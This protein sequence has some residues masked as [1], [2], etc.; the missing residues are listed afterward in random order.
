MT[1]TGARVGRGRAPRGTGTRGRPR[2]PETEQRAL[3]ATLDVFGRKGL[4]GLTIDEVAAVSKVGKSSI[5]L[6]WSNKE[7][8]LAA[9]LRQVQVEAGTG[10]EDG[11]SEAE[12]VRP[13]AISLRA[14]LIAHAQRRADLYLGEYGLAMLRLYAEARAYPALFADIREQAISRFVLAERR[15]VEHAIRDGVLPPE[16]SP[17]RILDAV[18]GAIFMHLLVTPPELLARVRAGLD[19]YVELMVDDQLR[20]AGYDAEADRRRVEAAGTA[21]A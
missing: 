6:R 15:H 21:S 4:A 14:F 11:A 13:G 20:A 16:A 9:A 1:E 7:T 2:D 3:H 18:E 12:P 8:L 19:E 17:V 10:R 5:Y